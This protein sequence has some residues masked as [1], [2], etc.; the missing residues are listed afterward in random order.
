MEDLDRELVDDV[1][2]LHVDRRIFRD[3]MNP[4]E[5]PNDFTFRRIY[6][7]TRPTFIRLLALLER[8]LAAETLRSRSLLPA[9]QLGVTLAVMGGNT[10]QSYAGMAL[11]VSQ[12]TVSRALS[13]VVDVV[14]KREREFITWPTGAEAAEIK[15]WF[16]EK[17]RI[18]GILGAIDGSHCRIQ[19]PRE[20]EPDYINRRRY[21]S[22]NIM[23]VST[24]RRIAIAASARFPGSS[25]DS[26]VFKQSRL[27]RELQAGLKE[28]TLLGDS[29][30]AAERFLLKPILRPSTVPERR[31]TEAICKGRAVVEN[32]FA[33]IKRQFHMLH[34]EIRYAPAKAAK[35]IGTAIC[36]RNFAARANDPEFDDAI[37]EEPV[38]PVSSPSD[39]CSAAGISTQLRIINEFFT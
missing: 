8:D 30:Y 1:L 9:Q 15:R 14:T 25:H 27:Y 20:R 10:F 35:L 33:T 12:A 34:G 38:Q 7:F 37:D 18:P 11:H 2:I 22:I 21:H 17:T 13:H 36:F 26:R 24:H 5:E 39:E 6:R 16:F 31:Y 4:L 29:A 19:A 32:Y 23:V 3:H 28:G